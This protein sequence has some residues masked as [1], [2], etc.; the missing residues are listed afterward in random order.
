MHR[1]GYE[2]CKRIFDLLFASIGLVCASPVMLL[3]AIAIKLDSHGPVIYR[4]VRIGK[5]AQPFFMYKARTMVVGAD[6]TDTATAHRDPRIT[7]VGALLRRAKLD[8]FPQLINVLRGEW[9]SP[10]SLA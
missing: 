6:R 1:S 3:I 5:G 8:E 10:P 2:F 4:G 7:C 9:L